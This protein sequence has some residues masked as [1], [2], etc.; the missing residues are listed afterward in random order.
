MCLC[1]NALFII[2]QLPKLQKF[3]AY[4]ISPPICKPPT[5]KYVKFLY[6][7]HTCHFLLITYNSTTYAFWHG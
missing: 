2:N 6:T 5:V 3:R 4:S 1:P 7:L